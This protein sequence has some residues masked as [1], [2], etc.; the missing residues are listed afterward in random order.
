MGELRPHKARFVSTP[1]R[2]IYLA[3]ISDFSGL[4]NAPAE[5]DRRRLPDGDPILGENGPMGLGATGGGH[6][7]PHGSD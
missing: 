4:C 1:N 6:Q 2:I 7:F 3:D 5:L